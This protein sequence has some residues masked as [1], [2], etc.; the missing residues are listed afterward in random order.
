[1]NRDHIIDEKIQSLQQLIKQESLSYKS[2]IITEEVNCI[3][4]PVK[5]PEENNGNK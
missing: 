5:L 4:L 2:Q 3:L 1:M